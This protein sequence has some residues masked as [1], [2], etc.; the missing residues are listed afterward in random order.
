MIEILYRRQTSLIKDNPPH[1]SIMKT[2][3]CMSQTNPVT[4]GLPKISVPRYITFHFL[5]IQTT[6]HDREEMEFLK[7]KPDAVTIL[8][9]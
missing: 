9:I 7:M 6:K 1:A 4:Q 5:M 3:V 8:R 2:S